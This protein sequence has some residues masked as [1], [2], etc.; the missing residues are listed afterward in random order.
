M[1][2]A[3][4]FSSM[5]QTLASGALA[6]ALEVSQAGIY[7]KEALA[8]A[9]VLKGTLWGRLNRHKIDRAKRAEKNRR[10]RETVRRPEWLAYCQA[11][12]ERWG[13]LPPMGFGRWLKE[14]HYCTWQSNPE[15]VLARP[16]RRSY[17]AARR[18]FDEAGRASGCA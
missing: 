9:G 8:A 17:D 7:S 13:D 1:A 14:K 10:W 16:N 3:D 15:L 5:V 12:R 4:A 6:R 18:A 11:H 2:A